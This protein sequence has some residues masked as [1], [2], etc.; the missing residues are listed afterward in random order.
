[1]AVERKL[2]TVVSIDFD[3]SELSLGEKIFLRHDAQ[4]QYDKNAIQAI[5][6]SDK[7][8]L[9]FVS[10]QPHTTLPGCSMNVD[11]LPYI[12]STEIPLVGQVVG[13]SEVSFMNGTIAPVV[14][15]E[16]FVVSKAQ[17]V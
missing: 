1:M 11:L 3:L 10:A 13:K 6:A 9:G 2:G 5:R 4:N 17:A 16:V 7:S 14:K 8:I 12:P 15:I